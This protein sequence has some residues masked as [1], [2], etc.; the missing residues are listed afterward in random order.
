MD[1][2]IFIR[3]VDPAAV[4]TVLDVELG[5]SMILAQSGGPSFN[6]TNAT[7]ILV[8]GQRDAD[9]PRG[10]YVYDLA[11]GAVR[12]I[13]EPVDDQYL[14]DAA[15][16]PD[17]RITYRSAGPVNDARVVAADGS[18]DHASD[19]LRGQ[20]SPISN[21]GTRIVAER[22]GEGDQAPRLVIA[23]INGDG[24]P[25]VLAC[26]P[27]TEIEC[28]QPPE[29]T[30]RRP[31]WV[32]SPDD[33]MLLAIILNIGESPT[34]GCDTAPSCEAGPWWETYLL[35]DAVTGHVTELDW[36]DVG[37]PAWQPVAP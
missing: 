24:E 37:T 10:I 16:L 22:D 15:W 21:D 9:G 29:P 1:A 25:V 12:T 30:Q 14:F 36:R 28:P 33:S 17:G 8:L 20:V 13:V 18:G 27:G 2:G 34:P 3:P 5:G 19:A 31:R 35:V 11:T 26:G 6:P 4:P 23:P 7:E 32:W